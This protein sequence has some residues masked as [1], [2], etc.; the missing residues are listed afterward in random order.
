M[1]W[2]DNDDPPTK[3]EVNHKD[4]CRTN[5]RADNLEWMSHADNIRYSKGRKNIAG[6]LNPNYGNRKLSVFY[7]DN[8]DIS[9]EKQSR[10]GLR[11]GRCK[12]ISVYDADQLIA[13]FEYMV[14]CI[15]F[16]RQHYSPEASPD[17]IRGQ[18]NKS[19]RNNTPYKGLTFVKH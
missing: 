10:L 18:I 2:V 3:N 15:E 17:S 14:P 19:V 5:N 11:N 9:K 16:I 4:Y 12:P 8:P 13:S 7:R 6:K 1:C